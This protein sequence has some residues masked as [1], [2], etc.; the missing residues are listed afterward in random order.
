[1][2][3]FIIDMPPESKWNRFCGKIKKM[4]PGVQAAIVAGIFSLAGIW[5]GYKLQSDGLHSKV[6]SLE[7]LVKQQDT[8]IRDRTAETQRLETLLAPF[9]TIALQRYTDPEPEALRKLAYRISD[10]ENSVTPRHLNEQQNKALFDILSNQPKGEIIVVS[11]MMDGEA[12]DYALQ[13]ANVIVNAGWETGINYML[14]DDTIGLGI[15]SYKSEKKL[16]MHDIIR[17]AFIRAGIDCMDVSIKN[18]SVPLGDKAE[19][20]LVVGRKR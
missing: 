3:N 5:L 8:T 7:A 18:N 6:N 1:M 11:R 4:H 15:C 20:L 16:P 17:K 9:R 13:L 2:S 14:A 19:L 12:K 10:I